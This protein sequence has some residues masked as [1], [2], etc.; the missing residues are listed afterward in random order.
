ME[1]KITPKLPD[2]LITIKEAK[3]QLNKF[4]KAHPGYH[5][6]EYAL[7]SWISLE[8]LENYLEFVKKTA[9]EKKIEVTGIEFIY[10]QYKDG[11][12]NMPNVSN[13]DFG[14]TLMLAPTSNLEERNVGI[15]ILNSEVG[16]PLKL[17]E[18]LVEEENSDSKLP[19]ENKL[20]GIA[21]QINSCPNMCF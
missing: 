15:D 14:L 16:Q 2:N 6:D 3:D 20:S 8:A 19:D 12:Q 13:N 1:I 5:G 10:T 11:N 17:S 9:L 18:I 7:R 21:N 4:K